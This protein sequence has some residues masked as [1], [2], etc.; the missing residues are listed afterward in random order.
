MRSPRFK[1]VAI[2]DEHVSAIA[3][4]PLEIASRRCGF[5]GWRHD[6]EESAAGREQCI[7]QT[8]FADARI[9]ENSDSP[10]MDFDQSSTIRSVAVAVKAV[11]RGIFRSARR[12]PN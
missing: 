1:I 11:T 4:S 3:L 8:V 9:R 6:L 2:D 10:K 5:L 7:V 12:Q